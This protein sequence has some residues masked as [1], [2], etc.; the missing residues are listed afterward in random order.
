MKIILKIWKSTSSLRVW[1]NFSVSGFRFFP[2]LFHLWL[3][4]II[5]DC[6]N[7]ILIIVAVPKVMF[8]IN[9]QLSFFLWTKLLNY[10]NDC[11]LLVYETLTQCLQ[12]LF[13]FL[14]L[15]FSVKQAE[16]VNRSFP[17]KF[18]NFFSEL[19]IIH[20]ALEKIIEYYQ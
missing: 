3:W 4:I 8:T 11:C 19:F 20:S 15:L 10:N 6:L 13:L 9:E 14:L 7:H 16:I 17:I 18:L 2:I 5:I 1:R 12:F